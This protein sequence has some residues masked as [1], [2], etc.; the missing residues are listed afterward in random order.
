LP[1]VSVSTDVKKGERNRLALDS[2]R[3]EEQ[4]PSPTFAA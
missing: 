1:P 2:S 4:D 3:E